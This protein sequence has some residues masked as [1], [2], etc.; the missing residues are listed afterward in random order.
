MLRDWFHI[1]IASHMQPAVTSRKLENLRGVIELDH[2]INSSLLAMER[3]SCRPAPAASL[4]EALPC[5][6]A[7]LADALPDSDSDTH[8]W[9]HYSAP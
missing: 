8:A 5:L 4:F 9:S 3:Q 6:L 2:D 1:A 7:N